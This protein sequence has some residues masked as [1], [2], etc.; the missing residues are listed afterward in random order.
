MRDWRLIAIVLVGL[1]V[2]ASGCGKSSNA[3]S[4]AKG[5]T[6]GGQ[7]ESG[8]ISTDNGVPL[9]KPSSSSTP[10]SRS[11]LVKRANAACRRQ[12]ERPPIKVTSAAEFELAI[13]QALSYEQTFYEELGKLAPPASLASDWGQI[14]AG[15]RTT[16]GDI[17][18]LRKYPH[19]TQNVAARPLF[20]NM[21][22]TR[23]Q[24]RHAARRVGLRDCLPVFGGT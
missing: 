11:E 15:T 1:A 18:A 10:L 13:P 2:L 7:R 23:I 24:M 3:R 14:V 6:S 19:V 22:Q 20:A 4:Q 16:I 8:R 9:V 21:A 17:V 5:T 12:S